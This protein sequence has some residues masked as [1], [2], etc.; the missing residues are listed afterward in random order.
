MF[1]D[2]ETAYVVAYVILAWV[3]T[4]LFSIYEI[5]L[6]ALNIPGLATT[7]SIGRDMGGA[8]GMTLLTVGTWEVLMVLAKRWEKRWEERRGEEARQIHQKWEDW[9]RRRMEAES[10][11]E[12]FTE[13]PP[14]IDKK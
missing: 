9:N 13:P 8:V 4:A 10:K 1:K 3:Y 5:F 2:H 14:Q 11:G 12:A 7:I 6:E